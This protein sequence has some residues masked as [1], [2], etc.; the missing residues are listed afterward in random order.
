MQGSRIKQAIGNYK[1]C[2][3]DGTH[4]TPRDI[5][6]EQQC[7]TLTW[8]DEPSMTTILASGAASP[9]VLR[10]QPF[11]DVQREL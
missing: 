6:L 5:E 1:L 4:K 11:E 3:V 10:T 7:V 9:S 8:S 2:F